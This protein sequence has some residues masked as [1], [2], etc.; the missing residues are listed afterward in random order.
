MKISLL[1]VGFVRSTATSDK[2]YTMDEFIDLVEATNYAANAAACENWG[3]YILEPCKHILEQ[4][5]S[6][7]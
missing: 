5:S 7:L 4:V 3:T 1:I 6:K 2:K